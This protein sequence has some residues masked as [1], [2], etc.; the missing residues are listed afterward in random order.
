MTIETTAA[1][2]PG[3]ETAQRFGH[4][5]ALAAAEHI[6]SSSPVLP[7]S[8]QVY[9]PVWATEPSL[10]LYFHDA[11]DAVRAF[12]EAF[13]GSVSV[14]ENASDAKVYTSAVGEVQKIRFEAW[15]LSA[16]GGAE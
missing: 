2:E 8:V 4:M 3:T 1:P 10:R 6:I 7:T 12:A 16:A 5:A 9:C 11:P 13:G 15:A 14:E